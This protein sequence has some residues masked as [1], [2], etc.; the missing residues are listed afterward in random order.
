LA[1]KDF[2]TV[3][4]FATTYEP[5]PVVIPMSGGYAEVRYGRHS[6]TVRVSA[7]S[8]SAAIKEQRALD[9]MEGKH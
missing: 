2:T 8:I 7:A 3:P 1:T 4:T 5:E 6:R 9:Q